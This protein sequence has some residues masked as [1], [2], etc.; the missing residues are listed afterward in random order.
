MTGLSKITDKILTEAR[1]D[2]EEKLRAADEECRKIK[3]E[4]SARAEEYRKAADTAA[5]REAEE[6]VSRARSGEA[7][8]AR[9][10]VLKVRGETV[11]RAFELAVDEILALPRDRYLELLISMLT[12]SLRIKL[13]DERVRRENGDD[14]ED[15]GIPSEC[16]VYLNERDLSLYGKDFMSAALPAAA[17]ITSNTVSLS[18]TPAR[19]NG[20]LILRYGSIEINC[21]LSSIIGQLRP[22]LEARVSHVLFPEKRA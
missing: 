19:I 1:L 9:N 2:A 8:S 17:Q 12:S 7:I 10:T 20:G 11:D 13:E 6:I 22:S 14:C 18:D 3:A 5:R 16:V 21:S 15:E 4:Y